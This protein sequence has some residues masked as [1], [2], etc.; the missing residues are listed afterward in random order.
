MFMLVFD[1]RRMISDYDHVAD[2]AKVGFLSRKAG[3]LRERLKVVT[4]LL[5]VLLRC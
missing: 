1:V 2:E 5:L 3:E 4:V